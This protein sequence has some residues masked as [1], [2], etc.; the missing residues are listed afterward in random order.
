VTH[1][2]VSTKIK[3]EVTHDHVPIVLFNPNLLLPHA[4]LGDTERLAIFGVQGTPLTDLQW[5]FSVVHSASET[6]EHF[7]YYNGTGEWIF[8][9]TNSDTTADA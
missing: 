5:D 1:P 7:L 3:V 4:N 6:L 8:E 2:D 9:F